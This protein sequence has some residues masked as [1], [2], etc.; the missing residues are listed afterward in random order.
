MTTTTE[1]TPIAALI[2][3]AAEIIE[4]V[5][6][7]SSRDPRVDQISATLQ[8]IS[9]LEPRSLSDAYHQLIVLNHDISDICDGGMPPCEVVTIL[10][11]MSRLVYAVGGALEAALDGDFN[12]HFRDYHMC[13]RLDPNRIEEAVHGA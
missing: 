4:H 10:H 11:R 1:P 5:D 2:A 13:A 8:S 6:D 9:Y 3:G 12:E 7:L